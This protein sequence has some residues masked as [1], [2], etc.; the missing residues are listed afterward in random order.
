MAEAGPCEIT[1]ME[2][3]TAYKGYCDL[4]Y[5]QV[6]IIKGHLVERARQAL[7]DTKQWGSRF[8]IRKAIAP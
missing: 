8:N 4:R 2:P 6:R 7:V 1:W 3:Y 5:V